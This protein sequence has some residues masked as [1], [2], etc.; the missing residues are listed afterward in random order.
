M[1]HFHPDF[2]TTINMTHALISSVWHVLQKNNLL[3][4]E[5]SESCNCYTKLIRFI[6]NMLK[7][8]SESKLD[9]ID[10][11]ERQDSFY[12]SKKCYILKRINYKNYASQMK[13]NKHNMEK[14][15]TET[16]S[17]KLDR[18]FWFNIK[19]IHYKVLKQ[20]IRF[21]C[22]LAICDPDFVI[23]SSDI[24]DSL[25]LFIQNIAFFDDL[26]LHENERKYHNAFYMYYLFFM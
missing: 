4:S 16:Y 22:H 24:E 1:E 25:H 15:R 2:L 18:N 14:H 11:V 3:R 21:L 23:R 5:S 26:I 6:I 12:A 19:K 7:K 17:E 8:C 9:I 10:N 20:G 13:Y